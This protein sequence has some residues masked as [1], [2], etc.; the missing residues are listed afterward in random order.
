[1]QYEFIESSLFTKMVYDYLSEED[2]T[3]FQQFLL[4]QP[5]A[6]DLIKG[7]G[8]VRKVRWARAGSGKSGGVRVCY[9]TR[10]TAGQILLLVIYAKSVRASISGAALKQLKEML[11]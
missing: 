10:N 8:G 5:D 4:E 7:S 6:G 3:A 1:M 9:Y 11:E 2:Y